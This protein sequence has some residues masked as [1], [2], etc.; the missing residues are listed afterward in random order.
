MKYPGTRRKLATVGLA[1][2]M[3]TGGVAAGAALGA[4]IVSGA[5]DTTTTT[6]A[7]AE[8]ATEAPEDVPT[9]DEMAEAH[10]QHLTDALQPLVDDGTLTEAQR[11]AVIAALEAAGP[12][13]G[14][15][16]GPGRGLGFDAAAEAIGITT[17]ELRT[18]LQDGSTIAEV[19]AANGVDRQAVIDAMVADLE[20]HLA[21]EVASGEHTQEEADAM[22]SEASERIA[23]M[24]D[25]ELPAG[26]PHG[27]GGPGGPFGGD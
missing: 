16:H 24:V 11:D 14:M 25:G 6:E 4:P 10:Q 5:Q 9:P 19:A 1:A 20:A 23:S 3:V 12:P 2:A 7:S 26:G 27:P 17:E 18:A 13:G 21:E 15:H 22:L 8:P